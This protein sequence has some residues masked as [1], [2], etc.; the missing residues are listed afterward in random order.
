MNSALSVLAWTTF[1][2]NPKIVTKTLE[3]EYDSM[4]QFKIR[5]VQPLS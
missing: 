2:L 5:A 4:F 3:G 1:E